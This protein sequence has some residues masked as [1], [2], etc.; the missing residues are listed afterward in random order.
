MYTTWEQKN[1]GIGNVLHSGIIEGHIYNG[2]FKHSEDYGSNF[3]NHQLNNYYGIYKES[4]I[5]NNNIG[6]LLSYVIGGNDTL[7]FS[8]S[9]DNFENLQVIYKFNIWGYGLCDL[10]YG[11]NDGEL[12]FYNEVNKSLYF[13]NND[14][15]FWVKKNTFTCPNLPIQG[16]TGGRLD[17]ELYML[18][19]YIQMAGQRK[20]IYIYH[21]LD[22]GETFT[23]KH[24]V[25]LGTDP[26]YA[27]FIAQDTLVEPGDTVQFTD[28]SN[29]AEIWEW[30]FNNDEIIDSYDQHPVW[31]YEDTGYYSVKLKIQASF[32]EDYAIRY[33][34]LH[35]TNITSINRKELYPKPHICCYPNPFSNF[36]TFDFLHY[37]KQSLITIYDITGQ[38]ITTLYKPIGIN[39]IVW[40]GKDKTGYKIKP[41]VYYAK[42]D[43]NTFFQKLILTE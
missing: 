16:I 19:E 33:D 17:G 15:Y 18:V 8:I 26:I 25:S 4:E 13:T 35:V 36:I 31:V 27:N 24:P 39:K 5:G 7:Y 30:D 43:N 6:Y 38:Q 12:F 22:N 10:S 23:V 42:F 3:I 28:L 40:D 29:E 20:H 37:P 41:G 9:Y 34:Y 11:N 2:A 21:S 14:G 32:V 1:S